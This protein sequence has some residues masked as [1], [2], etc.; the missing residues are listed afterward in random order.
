MAQEPSFLWYDLETWGIDARADR[1]AQFAC[2][3]TNAALEVIEEPVTLWFRP[4]RDALPSPGAVAVTGLDPAELDRR[5]LREA[6]GIAQIQ[7]LMATPGTCSVGWNSLRF[8]DEFIRY[9]LYRNFFDPYQREWSGGNSR[10]DLL[11][12]AR[13]CHALRPEG[14]EW[15]AREDGAPSFRL[16]HLAAANGIA[17]GHAHD[18]MSDVEAT[19]GLARLLRAQQPRLW[20][21]HLKFRD[22]R[23]AAAL[24]RPGGE[25]LLHV[26]SRFPAQR[27]CAGIVL[28]LMPHPSVG[29]QVLVAELSAPIEHWI[30]LP[31]D[32]LARRLF[33]PGQE[34]EAEG[35]TRP[36]I[37]GVHLNRCPAL[38]QRQHVRHE[39]W[40]RLG[41]DPAAA[42]P[43]AL[44][45]RDAGAALTD[46]LTLAFDRQHPPAE[47]VDA[48]L[49]D[50]LPSRED[51]P[52]RQRI[53]RAAPD[54]LSDFT[55]RFR[56]P[57]GD[58]LLF[59]YRA[60]NWP[61]SLDADELARWR[62]HQRD[63]LGGS[64][65]AAFNESLASLPEATPTAL[66]EA[67]ADWRDRL[68]E[69]AGLSDARALP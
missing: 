34:L 64:A 51:A 23:E 22:K 14:I 2:I 69:E 36:P 40:Q 9:G 62:Q 61:A 16:E 5:G 46:R 41:L 12:F 7:A 60:R 39:E 38:I 4:P 32:E 29:N 24:L 3:R 30:D 54:A 44:A 57:R 58:E 31:A 67:L 25:L 59:R 33:S 21:Y 18:A 19:L 13:L 63:R 11:D 68:L 52:L 45:I 55:G 20:D 17:H 26:S 6:E 50:L 56:D 47:D 66:R 8:D 53:Q 48:A 27:H 65:L 37:K 49:Y 1:I 42:E 28:P 15:P 43:R 35:L 10:W